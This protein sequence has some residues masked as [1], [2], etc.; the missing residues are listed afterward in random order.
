MNKNWPLYLKF[1]FFFLFFYFLIFGNSSQFL[2]SS[3][4]EKLWQ[5]VIPWF[6]G[7][8]GHDSPIEVFTNGSGDTT[9]NYYQIYFFAVLSIFGALIFIFIKIKPKT[10][11]LL[12]RLLYTF[13]RY[14]L[15]SQMILYGLAKVFY[16]Q[17][18]FPSPARLDQELGDF[19]PMGLLWTFMGY[20]KG[21]TIFTGALELLGGLLLLTRRTTTLGALVTFGVMLNVMMLN[22]CYDVPVKILSTNLVLMS[23]YLIL[24]DGKRLIHFFINTKSTIPAIPTSIVPPRFEKAKNIVKWIILLLYLGVSI[25]FYVQSMYTYGHKAPKPPFYGKYNVES[26]FQYDDSLILKTVPDS[27]RWEAFYQTWKGYASAKT[28]S[29]KVL[30]LEFHPDTTQQIF[31]INLRNQSQTDTLY[32]E[33]LDSTR[34]RVHGL[35]EQDSLDMIFRKEAINDRLLIKRD[36]RWINEYPFNR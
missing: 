18:R 2:L 15:A 7:L 20:S 1:G 35:F 13:L 33:H 23:L 26:F 4:L 19:S 31:K 36:F 17:F 32:Y 14:Y 3:L 10:L 29:G 9:Y 27:V 21:Y 24:L 22:Y 11:D 30:R 8:V 34:L 28:A 16:L 5:K 25:F 12:H 6:A